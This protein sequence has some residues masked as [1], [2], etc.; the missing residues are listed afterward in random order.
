M[1]CNDSGLRKSETGW[2]VEGDP[3]EGALLTSAM[4][5]GY[6]VRQLEKELPRLDT[7]PFESERQYMATLHAQAD[8]KSGVIYIKGSVES[9]CLECN[10]IFGPD[11]Q[12]E[13]PGHKTIMD[14][15]ESMADGGLRVLAFARKEVAPDKTEI[16][17][18]DLEHGLEFLGLQGMID[19]PGRKR[20]RW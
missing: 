20:S 12:P 13:I 7:I 10:T 4:K 8:G 14:W 16:T 1:L 9:I 17:H 2:K 19:R 18:A 3:T 6:D 11:G 15:V 5:F